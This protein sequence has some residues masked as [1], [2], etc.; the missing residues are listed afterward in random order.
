MKLVHIL[1]VLTAAATVN[2]ILIPTGNDRSPQASGTFSRVSDPTNEPTPEIPDEDWQDIM[3]IINSS[4]SNQDQQQSIDV[5][6]PST[7]KLAQERP[8]DELG[9]S[10][11]EQ[12]WKAIIDNPDPGIPE[13][14]K[15]LIDTVNSNI[16]NQDQQQPIDVAGS[17]TSKRGR[18]RPADIAGPN[19]SKRIRQQPIDVAGP[20]TSRQDQ[21]QPMDQGESANTVTDQ[22]IGLSERYQ[23][24]FNRIKKRLL[25]SKVVREKKHKEYRDYAALRFEQWSALARGEEI[26]GSRYDPK[27]EKQLKQEY[28]TAGKKIYVVRQELKAFMK[29]RGLEF[30]EPDLD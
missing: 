28:L 9:P 14:W 29:R 3:D 13:D 25:A 12:D 4:T 6:D 23:R 7:S 26:S 10:I 22:V 16:D 5:V 8:I 27:V 30:E 15:D 11:S 21:Q 18:K 24:T 1:F 17:S 19:V 20:S 2:A